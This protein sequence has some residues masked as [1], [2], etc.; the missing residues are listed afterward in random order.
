MGQQK[1]FEKCKT[2]SKIKQT[3]PKRM[4]LEESGIVV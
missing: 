3:K 1:G 2:K 4:F